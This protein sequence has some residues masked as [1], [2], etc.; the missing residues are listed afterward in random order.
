M[1][2]T[3]IYGH[4][5]CM[6]TYPE[7]TLLGFQKAIEQGV[8]GLELDV[9]LTKDGEVVVIHDEILDRTTNGNGYIK[10]FTL[11]EVKQFSAGVN[12]AHFPEYDEAS[13]VAERVPTLKEVLELLAP[14]D[15]ELNIELKT[16]LINYEGIEE[17]VLSIV[18]QFGN[19]RKIIFSSFHLPTLLRI[20]KLNKYA[21]IAWL[22]DQ[23]IS[24]PLDYIQGLDLEALHISK[25]VALSD[26][27]Y[28]KEIF[29]KIRVWTVNDKDEIKQLLDLN[30]N[31]IITDFPE[32]ALFYRSERKSFV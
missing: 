22:L 26:A 28:L 27:Y 9:Q 23:R 4:R 6:G 19:G 31:A 7:N 13:W 25:H 8:D 30:V 15:I 24:H 18:E 11:L 32:R 14:Y 21:E 5:G 29:E 17:K 12:Y 1:T 16:Y 3:K 20:K 2:A 10:D